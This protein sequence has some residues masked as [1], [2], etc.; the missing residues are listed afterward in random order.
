M[1]LKKQNLG[2]R[3]ID[4]DDEF[5]LAGVDDSVEKGWA[6]QNL[7]CRELF[8]CYLINIK[9]GPA[10]PEISLVVRIA[11][12]RLVMDVDAQNLKWDETFSL[13][14]EVIDLQHQDLFRFISEYVEACMRLAGRHDV[15]QAFVRMIHYAHTH[16]RDEEQWMLDHGYPDRARHI[17]L[18]QIFTRDIERLYQRF[19]SGENHAAMQLAKFAV[20]WITHHVKSEDMRIKRFIAGPDQPREVMGDG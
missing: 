2:Y 8:Q 6:L 10:S 5:P 3:A 13:G 4:G 20:H 17:G 7:L 19:C 1:V 15:E 11:L 18:H 12:R 9:R 14:I 16:F